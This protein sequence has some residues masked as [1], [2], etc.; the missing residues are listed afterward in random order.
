V[1][2]PDRCFEGPPPTVEGM[3]LTTYT[4]TVPVIL[5]VQAPT[6][7]AAILLAAEELLARL[8]DL[9]GLAVAEFAAEVVEWSEDEAF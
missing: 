3:N 5:N 7:E 8:P 1:S 9:D 2:T 4:V 6:Q